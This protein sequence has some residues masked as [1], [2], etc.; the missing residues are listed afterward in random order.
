MGIIIS[1]ENIFVR[2]AVTDE[3][4]RKVFEVRWLG[5]QGYWKSRYEVK[6]KNDTAPNAIQL[7]ANNEDDYPIGTIRILDRNNGEIELDSF[8]DVDSLLSDAEKP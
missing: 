5:Y 1:A 6:D 8:L 2:K 4:L 7:L 3:D